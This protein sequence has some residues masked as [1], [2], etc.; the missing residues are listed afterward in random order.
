MDRFIIKGQ[1]KL[2]G[3]VNISGSKN[4][5]LPLIAAS[6]L[7][8]GKTVIR[9]A[10]N[11]KDVITML[12][13]I[14]GLGAKYKFENNT[15]WIDTY[16]LNS[17]IAPY[18]LVKTMRAS[19]YVLGPLLARLGKAEVSLPG[20]CAIGP[21]P[22]NLHIDAIAKLGAKIEIK[23]GFIYA[24]ASKLKGTEIM[25][26]KSSVGAT[27]NTI[28]AAVLAQ[29]TTVIKNAA[30]EPEIGELIRF[31][32]KMGA[33]IKGENT[34]ILYINGVSKL[35]PTEHTVVPDRI[36]AGT[37][38]IA[39]VITRS[40][41]TVN[42]VVP[43]HISSLTEVLSRMNVKLKIGD[44]YIKITG[45]D[46]LK[47]VDIKTAIYPGF[48]T[49]LQPQMTSLLAT[50]PGTS[51]INETIFENRFTHIPE[52][53]R[54]GANIEIDEHIAIIRGVKKLY[55]AP[56]MAS[57][58]RGGAALVLAGLVAKGE[59]TVNRVYHIDRGYE[60]IENKLK[61]LGAKIE[62]IGGEE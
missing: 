29:G 44:N 22:V 31:L 15:I 55:G 50:V 33:D 4:A 40:Y 39:G 54:M 21:R 41:I 16:K 36:E 30:L 59:T 42:N 61:N 53:I 45:I 51:V 43:E 17:Y 12:N 1:K 48:P 34:N 19:I 32:K 46:S 20:G 11:L 35:N 49:D 6:L 26:E 56:I 37:F 28:M 14:S 58:L 10:P 60:N 13:V 5:T 8:K 2:T 52:L 57:D 25:F 23:E 18:E 24:K 62:R 3:T 27:A 38:I 47:P 9:N 7:T